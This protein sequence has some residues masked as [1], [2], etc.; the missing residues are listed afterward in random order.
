MTN[1]IFEKYDKIELENKNFINK[2]EIIIQNIKPE[3]N[4]KDMVEML[5]NNEILE[6][7]NIMTKTGKDTK[8]FIMMIKLQLW[9]RK[10]TNYSTL[11]KSKQ[12]DLLK[13]WITHP[14]TRLWLVNETEKF[15][16]DEHTFKDPTE[17]MNTLK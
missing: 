15:L 13:K 1:P 3:N 4:L 10:H 8:V 16:N 9:L 14:D 11:S 2:K 17:Y 6:W 5:S 7:L 12:R